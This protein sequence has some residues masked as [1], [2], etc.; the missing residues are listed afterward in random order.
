LEERLQS[1]SVSWWWR[2]GRGRRGRII[3]RRRGVV[4]AASIAATGV[5][6]IGS[7]ATTMTQ[8]RWR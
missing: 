5:T 1:S 4:T 3:V 2:R 7:V 6:R 8:H